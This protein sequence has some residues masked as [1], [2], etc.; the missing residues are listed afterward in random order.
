MSLLD[1]AKDRFEFEDWDLVGPHRAKP[2]DEPSDEIVI[3]AK[4]MPLTNWADEGL[5]ISGIKTRATEWY[6]EC[7]LAGI[8]TFRN[9]LRLIRSDAV[10]C[11]FSGALAL[12]FLRLWQN[13]LKAPVWLRS[14][15][16]SISTKAS[17]EIC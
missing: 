6:F 8:E 4:P 17:Y 11:P 14:P 7:T 16:I 5:T 9:L 3:F 2:G 12:Q 13:L 10:D 15:A 1:L